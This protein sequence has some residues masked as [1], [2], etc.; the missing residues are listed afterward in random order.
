[1]HAR[2]R[3]WSGRATF[4]IPNNS[5]L[6]FKLSR[7]PS[8]DSWSYDLV[9]TS[10]SAPISTVPVERSGESVAPGLRSLKSRIDAVLAQ[11]SGLLDQEPASAGSKRKAPSVL[12]RECRPSNGAGNPVK[13]KSSLSRQ[14]TFRTS[15]VRTS[16]QRRPET[17]VDEYV[18][19]SSSSG[20]ESDELPVRLPAISKASVGGSAAAVAPCAEVGAIGESP[21]TEEAVRTAELELIKSAECNTTIHI[22]NEAEICLQGQERDDT[23]LKPSSCN[24]TREE[25][26]RRHSV[27]PARTSCNSKTK[28]TRYGTLPVNLKRPRLVS[29]A[30]TANKRVRRNV[31][32][33]DPTAGHG[34]AGPAFDPNN[35][36]DRTGV[37]PFFDSS[38]RLQPSSAFV[39]SMVHDSQEENEVQ[40]VTV[41]QKMP[42]AAPLKDGENSQQWLDKNLSPSERLREMESDTAVK[43]FSNLKRDHPENYRERG[44][45]GTNSS[46]DSQLCRRENTVRGDGEQ[47]MASSD[48]RAGFRAN[49]RDGHPGPQVMH[50][51]ETGDRVQS[52]EGYGQVP[53]LSGEGNFGKGLRHRVGSVNSQPQGSRQDL[54]STVFRTGK[55]NPVHLSPS[56]MNRVMS[57]F[58]DDS[59]DTE[60]RADASVPL[61]HVASALGVSSALPDPHSL[62]SLRKNLY[63]RSLSV[64]E[65]DDSKVLGAT[66]NNGQGGGDKS[67]FLFKTA[68]GKPF[69]I[70]PENVRRVQSIFASETS[71]TGEVG[72]VLAHS[73]RCI[74]GV[75]YQAPPIRQSFRPV[76]ATEAWSTSGGEDVNNR[77]PTKENTAYRL[78]TGREEVMKVPSES[79]S[80]S[81]IQVPTFA[82]PGTS[83]ASDVDR[84]LAPSVSQVKS[85]LK[86]EIRTSG[87]SFLPANAE[88]VISTPGLDK[89]TNQDVLITGATRAAAGTPHSSLFRT[90]R[91]TPVS[92]SSAALQRIRSIFEDG[93][94]RIDPEGSISDSSLSTSER[95]QRRPNGASGTIHCNSD[96]IGE[97]GQRMQTFDEKRAINTTYRVN[98]RQSYA[99]KTSPPE[100]TDWSFSF[101]GSS[102]RTLRVS[103][104]ARAKAEALL[105]L[106]PEFVTPLKFQA[107]RP[108]V[109]ISPK[110][111]ESPAR[112]LLDADGFQHPAKQESRK[113]L[114][115]GVSKN[116]SRRNP[117]GELGSKL[118]F[119]SPRLI[120]PKTDLQN[121]GNCRA[122]H[123]PGELRTKVNYL[124]PVSLHYLHG[125]ISRSERGRLSI[126]EYFGGPPR[127]ESKASQLSHEVLSLTADTAEKY[128]I[129]FGASDLGVEDVWLVLRDLG[130]DQQSASQGWVA[131]HFKWIVWKLASYE[132]KFSDQAAGIL[133]L[134]SVLNELKYRYDRE[135]NGERS[136]LRRITE[137]DASAGHTMVLCV[138]AIRRVKDLA[139]LD[140]IQVDKVDIVDGTKRRPSSAGVIEVT[141]GW[142]R[143]NAQ[144]DV[145]L[146]RSI[147]SGKLKGGQKIVVCGAVLEGLSEGLPPLQAYPDAYLCLNANGVRRARWDQR[148]GF[149]GTAT[150]LAFKCI[151]PDGGLIPHTY[152]AITRRYPVLYREKLAGGG[153]ILRSDRA[154]D[155]TAQDFDQRW[156]NLP[157]AKVAE[158]AMQRVEYGLCLEDEGAK[159]F[160]ALET[161]SDPESLLADMTRA[162]LDAFGAYKA[163]REVTMQTAAGE[164]IKA[165]LESQGLAMREVTPTFRVRVV[166][167]TRVRETASSKEGLVTVWQATE[168]LQEQLQEGKVYCV[169]GLRPTSKGFYHSFSST[170]WRPVSA[171]YL[172]NNYAF[173]YVPRAPLKISSLSEY[174]S[175]REFDVVGL[176][177]S[178]TDPF[179]RDSFRGAAKSQW[180]FITDGSCAKG[181]AADAWEETQVLA[182]EVFW[183]VE[184]FVP[185][186]SSLVGS[187]VGF[188][189]LWLKHRDHVNRLWVAEASDKA[190]YSAK[191]TSSA[192]RHLSTAASEVRKWAKLNTW[193]VEILQSDVEEMAVHFR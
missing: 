122:S 168:E 120:R 127:P 97:A 157:R 184:A 163:R 149:C 65:D 47:A 142:Y 72:R 77:F 151:K 106:E 147:H 103:S 108:S 32:Q 96:S 64:L 7:N 170:R 79:M 121:G 62:V 148:L 134:S 52:N 29:S 133:T 174:M 161:A 10:F 28:E 158:E 2:T 104:A 31:D 80:R 49:L 154:E 110:F 138:S 25:S 70:D 193:N 88:E 186:E 66:V 36:S 59:P 132:R 117:V 152:V 189:N 1:M 17:R 56:A 18:I 68:G 176:V 140:D 162:Q 181:D 69:N 155:R 5:R 57:L 116:V 46:G 131:N 8:S 6:N 179:P 50:G 9:G 26:S 90:G 102:G 100:A 166:G 125:K 123:S 75:K 82:K 87:Q 73:K 172:E 16:T 118:A 20:E 182:V 159:L 51:R 119:K 40:E 183:P 178:V 165:A 38:P 101:K 67:G 76:S 130:A 145:P 45:L 74:V 128:R 109:E 185:I 42:G 35:A 53:G 3:H 180:V 141:D 27:A 23:Q 58:A 13:L 95:N 39:D 124:L 167:L 11:A 188:C 115:I 60:K 37:A 171:A 14:R 91:N 43:E 44:R 150:P 48:S 146:A 187:V 192:F 99:R 191:L 137:R 105:K 114:N 153:Y 12:E 15:V 19:E 71:T 85:V 41:F 55:G 84:A 61:K 54:L 93:E 177:L 22:Q 129:P 111:N 4:K 94:L 81:Q 143:L 144:I 92:I 113:Q 34:C 24:R 112:H 169:Y 190:H 136:A 78:Q 135:L 98:P 21:S 83:P 86:R 139:S 63:T 173:S 156:N 175:C 33:T 126:L 30:E 160:A 164:V 89:V 107:R